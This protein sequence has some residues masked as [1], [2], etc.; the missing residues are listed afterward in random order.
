MT[1]KVYI[2]GLYIF[3][4]YFKSSKEK[5]TLSK[6]VYPRIRFKMTEKSVG[7]FSAWGN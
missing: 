5:N 7:F 2:T 1:E 6:C 4:A 3:K